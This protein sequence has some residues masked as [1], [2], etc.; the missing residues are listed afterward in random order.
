MEIS[1]RNER[2]RKLCFVEDEMQKRLGTKSAE[3]LKR[4][5]VQLNAAAAL[6]ELSYLRPMRCHE[7]KGDRKGQYSVDLDGDCG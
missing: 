6:S 3:K 5:M 4:R 2:L 7:L 1:F